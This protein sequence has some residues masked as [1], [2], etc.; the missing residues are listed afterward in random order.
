VRRGA[1]LAVRPRHARGRA[2]APLAA[3]RP[4]PLPTDDTLQG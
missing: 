2:G 1:G 3:P 4:A